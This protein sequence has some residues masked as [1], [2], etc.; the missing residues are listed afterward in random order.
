LKFLRFTK[1]GRYTQRDYKEAVHESER[2]YQE[3]AKS[4][5]FNNYKPSPLFPWIVTFSILT[6]IGAGISS[7]IVYELNS[8]EPTFE[9]FSIT[10]IKKESNEKVGAKMVYVRKDN[11]EE[12]VL[13][14]KND[15]LVKKIN[16]I[17]LDERL[18]VGKRG[19]AKIAHREGYPKDIYGNILDIK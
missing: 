2:N 19:C 1:G 18:F 9:E 6:A 16:E 4:R 5:W 7:Y 17:Q 15:P 11:G 8:M 10:V 3:G 12:L 14:N 13:R